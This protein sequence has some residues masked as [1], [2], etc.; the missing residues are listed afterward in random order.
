ME[1]GMSKTPSISYAVALA[2]VVVLPLLVFLA[3]NG[4]RR[5]RRT[6]LARFAAREY[7]VKV[8]G[9]TFCTCMTKNISSALVPSIQ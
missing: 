5:R 7:G 9:I 6:R 3:V 1:T 4:A 8:F 2:L